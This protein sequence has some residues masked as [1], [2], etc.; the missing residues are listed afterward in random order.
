M[1]FTQYT[2]TMEFLREALAH[3]GALTGWTVMSYSG[4]GGGVRDAVGAWSTISRDEAKRRF[5]AGRA[6]LLVCTDAAA[7]GLNFQFCGALV[8]YD[9]PWNP[10]RVEQRIGRI[11]RL[12]QAFEQIQIVNLHYADTVETDIY[13]ALRER[14]GLFTNVVGKLQPILAQLP[15]AIRGAVLT[16]AATHRDGRRAA[17]TQIEQQI[18]AAQQASFDID[19]DTAVDFE[20]SERQESP[21]TLSELG[22]VL[23]DPSLLPAGV[24]ADPMGGGEMSYGSPGARER[25]RVTT[26]AAFYGEHPDSVELWSPGGPVFPE[27]PVR[28]DVPAPDARH[29]TDLL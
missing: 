10:M 1:I 12:G 17:T 13:R 25:V 24:V 8:N 21:I 20:G 28:D 22:R 27:K 5:K 14:I 7:E 15:S 19:E 3:E 29:L 26:S 16:G 11:D 23:A 6:D 4:D 2:D 9:M 18:A